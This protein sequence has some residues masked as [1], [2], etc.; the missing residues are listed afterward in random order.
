[1]L[2]ILLMSAKYEWVFSS[3]KYLITDSYSHLK[4]DIIKVNECLKSWY[5]RLEAKAFKWGVNPD[6]DDLYKEEA[7]AKAKAAAEAIA[8]ATAKKDS[9][10]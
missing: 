4:A 7:K 5:G 8:G 2:A 10:T 6:V 1:M 9:N 3:T